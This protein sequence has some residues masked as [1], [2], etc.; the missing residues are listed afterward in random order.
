ME[1][2]GDDE[3][4]DESDVE[5][6]NIGQENEIIN[7]GFDPISKPKTLAMVEMEVET[8]Q[9]TKAKTID[10]N[11]ITDVKQMNISLPYSEGHLPVPISFPNSQKIQKLSPC[12]VRNPSATLILSKQENTSFSP[13]SIKGGVIL[14]IPQIGSIIEDDISPDDDLLCRPRSQSLDSGAPL[15]PPPL[16]SALLTE[17]LSSVPCS[18]NCG[19]TCC[20]GKQKYST[21]GSSIIKTCESENC[22]CCTCYIQP[23]NPVAVPFLSGSYFKT[24]LGPPTQLPSS[25]IS[26]VNVGPANNSRK[27]QRNHYH[28]RKY[29]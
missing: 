16:S 23:S 26:I 22:S 17:E 3:G 19:S 29:E 11:S 13:S 4:E 24:T 25:G 28:S 7:D 2:E 8:F 9:S 5:K 18:C 20:S 27:M 14:D 6:E 15:V 21:Q 10:S 12:I 1:A